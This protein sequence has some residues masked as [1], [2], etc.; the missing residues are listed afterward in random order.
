MELSEPPKIHLLFIHI[1]DQVYEF[2]GISDMAEDYVEKAHQEGK[3]LDHLVARI[4]TQNFRQQE[5][6]KIWCKWLVSDPDVQN[7]IN[8]VKLLNKRQGMST[9]KNKSDI[10]REI[11][12][13][14][15]QKIPEDHS[16]PRPL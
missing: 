1:M 15:Q 7:Q 11:K 6:M 2:G 9:Q 3:K 4:N 10:K 12:I 8:R 13:K 16:F 5:L 14:K